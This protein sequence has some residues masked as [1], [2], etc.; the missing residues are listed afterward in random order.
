MSE[1]TLLKRIRKLVVLR[2]EL[3]AQ[4]DSVDRDLVEAIGDARAEGR[5]WGQIGRSMGI[6]RKGA[7]HW[8]T[9]HTTSSQQ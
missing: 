1:Q 3:R 9:H 5:T 8:Y 4:L 2:V 7:H 6:N